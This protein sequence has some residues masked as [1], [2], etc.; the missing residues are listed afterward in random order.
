LVMRYIDAGTLKDLITQHG[1][2]A[3]SEAARILDQVGRALG[4][5]HN[6]GVVHRD[7]KPTNV[8]IDQRGDAYLT[9][10]GIAKLVAGTSQFTATGAIVGTPAY[11]SPEQ[12]LADP[13]DHRSDIYSLGVVLYE[14][15]TGRVPFE[16]ETPLA[17]LLKHINAPLPPPRQIKPDLPEEVERVILKAMAK[18]PD[19]RFQR[20]EEMI[21]ALQMGLA[22]MSTEFAL[23][24]P[25]V[26]L[27]DV[28]DVP[29]VV[30]PT[31]TVPPPEPSAAPAPPEPVPDSA[32][33]AP[34]RKPLPL[35]RPWLA[36]VGVATALAV[37]LIAALLILPNLGGQEAEATLAPQAPTPAEIIVDNYGPRFQ[38]EAGDWGV[39]YKGECGGVNYAVDFLYADPGCTTCRARFNLVVPAAGEY[40]VWTWWPQG[41]DRSTDTPFT[42]I[43]HGGP[44]TINVNQR[45]N[46]SAWYPLGTLTFDAGESV[47]IV[48]TGSD[49]GY[50]N[51]DA[52][53]LTPAGA[54]PP[55]AQ[56]RPGALLK[57]TAGLLIDD[58]ERG[59]LDDRWWF[60]TGE[61]VTFACTLDQPG[62]GSGHALRLPFQI[63]AEGYA[64]CGTDVESGPWSDPAGLRFFWRSDEPGLTVALILEMVDPTQ[65]DPNADGVTPFEVELLTPGEEWARVTLLWEDFTKAEWVGESGAGVLD[66]TRVSGLYFSVL[67][68]RDAAVWFDDLQLVG[69]LT[70][71]PSLS[72]AIVVDNTYPDFTIEA[73]DWG[74]CGKRDCGGVSYEAD[75]LYAD[76]G[77]TACRARFDFV[78]KTAGEYD[79]WTWWPQGGDRSTDT[80]FT[81]MYGDGPLTIKVDQRGEGSAWYRLGT[82]TFDADESVSVVVAGSDTGYANAD[83]V[84]LTPATTR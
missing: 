22:H 10:F 50:A 43:Y 16:A 52:V 67:E 53:A 47:S 54:G 2:L 59:D 33:A 8:M 15:V 17:V 27:A 63:G 31:I 23:P 9:D 24:R 76:P 80:P 25:A 66:P 4:Y 18:S 1:P 7:I 70:S 49:T 57:A 12:G 21:E 62:Y 78:V 14:M 55:V 46:G 58:F 74:D 36:L 77:C 60:S 44:F 56:A 71:Q 45:D 6:Q 75:F 51:A 35:A 26:G 38:I 20:T 28:T 65:T 73:G 19:D 37:V 29:L 82:F 34:S 83:A 79:V 48:V 40:D 13:V 39:C 69:D 11:M 5:A 30:A 64:D 41:D 84:A 3:L 32:V 72:D 61:N 81:V 42:V 68:E